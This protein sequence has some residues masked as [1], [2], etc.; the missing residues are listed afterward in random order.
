MGIYILFMLLPTSLTWVCEIWVPFSIFTKQPTFMM[1]NTVWLASLLNAGWKNEFL[2]PLACCCTQGLPGGW[3]W[4]SKVQISIRVGSAQNKLMCLDA[5]SA[6]CFP[7]VLLVITSTHPLFKLICS[8]LTNQ[9][10]YMPKVGP[11]VRRVLSEICK[12]LWYCQSFNNLPGQYFLCGCLG[13]L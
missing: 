13:E 2:S 1:M 3:I 9:W 12:L 7:S 4:L 11:L 10:V 8:H 5:L 6:C